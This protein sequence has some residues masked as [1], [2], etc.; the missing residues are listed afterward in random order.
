MFHFLDHQFLSL[1]IMVVSG[2]VDS[3]HGT[4]R[5]NQ[6]VLSLHDVTIARFPLTLLI[7]GVAVSDSVVEL[8]AGVRL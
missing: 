8:V 6:R 4:I 5:F 1:P 2:V 7:A 3:A